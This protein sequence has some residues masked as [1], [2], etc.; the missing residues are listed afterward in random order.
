M[1][2]RMGGQCQI[3]GHGGSGP[4]KATADR[5]DI[6]TIKSA[7]TALNSSLSTIRRAIRTPVSTMTIRRRKYGKK[8]RRRPSECLI[9]LCEAVLASRLETFFSG[10]SALC[11]V[12]NGS[13]HTA[14]CIISLLGLM[15]LKEAPSSNDIY[16]R[17]AIPKPLVT[18]VN[19]ISPQQWCHTHK[20]WYIVK[21]KKLLPTVKFEC[22]CVIIW[23]AESWFPAGPIG[24][25]KG[26]ITGVNCRE[27]L[28]VLV[29]FVLR[30]SFPPEDGIFQEDNAPIHVAELVQSSFDQ[31]KDEVKDLPW[32][33][34]LPDL[35]IIEPLWSILKRSI[36]NRYHLPASLPELSQH[37]N[38]EYYNIPLNTIFST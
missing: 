3:S 23:A 8:I 18:D 27:I 2:A 7:V 20:T 1:M 32:P 31:P 33:P 17:A 5:D 34:Q 28:A 19:A 12:I 15:I 21:W 14:K 4:P 22:G 24:T 25:L 13:V 16:G 6:L 10:D 37:L 9:T 30:T 36:R 38:E 26:R 35:N 29:Y 11:Q